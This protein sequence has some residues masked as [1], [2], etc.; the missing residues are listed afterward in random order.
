M[1]LGDAK[2]LR[3]ESRE[4]N[5]SFKKTVRHQILPHYRKVAAFTG[6]GAYTRIKVSEPLEAGYAYLIEIH[7]QEENSKFIKKN[8]LEVF[9]AVNVKARKLF[10]EIYKALLRYMKHAVLQIHT[11]IATSL[12]RESSSYFR[13][14]AFA[15]RF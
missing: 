5:R 14:I 15:H 6:K 1:I 12:V 2:S 11:A 3:D 13:C 9:D 4:A 8:H 10:E 7:F